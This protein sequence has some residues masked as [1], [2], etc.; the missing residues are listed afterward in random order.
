M[1]EKDGSSGATPPGAANR[2]FSSDASVFLGS[3]RHDFCFSFANQEN[4]N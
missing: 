1:R 4:S 3:A 2:V